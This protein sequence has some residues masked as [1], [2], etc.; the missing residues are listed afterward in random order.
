[1]SHWYFFFVRHLHHLC[2]E[3]SQ[4]YCM[5][6][7]Y[8]RHKFSPSHDYTCT[9]H[10]IMNF[11]S[12]SFYLTESGL[13]DVRMRVVAS[14]KHSLTSHRFKI[15][16]VIFLFLNFSINLV[17]FSRLLNVA[18]QLHIESQLLMKLRHCLNARHLQPNG[19]SLILKTTCAK[20]IRMSLA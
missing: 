17:N 14:D 20:K 1:M 7:K 15:Q 9:I 2:P 5:V 8:S 4:D 16:L 10:G 18:D 13:E 3:L 19:R 11:N 6:Q 12:R